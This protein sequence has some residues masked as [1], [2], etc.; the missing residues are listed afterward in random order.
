MRR[1][2][3][4]S[5]TQSTVGPGRRKGMINLVS[6]PRPRSRTTRALRETV[7]APYCCAHTAKH[8]YEGAWQSESNMVLLQVNMGEY[9]FFWYP[10]WVVV[11]VMAPRN[12]RSTRPSFFVFFFFRKTKKSSAFSLW[13]PQRPKDLRTHMQLF[14]S[15]SN[16]KYFVL[17]T[18]TQTECQLGVYVYL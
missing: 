14:F 13:L 2:A 10:W 7:V 4:V 18:K 17:Q 9:A 8:F 5:A 6:E 1:H 3:R 15:C 16:S 12:R 11:P